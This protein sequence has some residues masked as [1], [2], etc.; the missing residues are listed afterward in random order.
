MYTK[1]STSIK[2]TAV[3]AVL[4]A[5]ASAPA[6]A[7]ETTPETNC[8]RW[9]S[10]R[11]RSWGLAIRFTKVCGIREARGNMIGVGPWYCCRRLAARR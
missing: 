9:R 7:G 4:A 6:T 2:S 11:E 10:C 1:L 3:A 5:M 8:G